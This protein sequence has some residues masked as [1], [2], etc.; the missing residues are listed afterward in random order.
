MALVEIFDEMV[1]HTPIGPS[2]NKIPIGT[3]V[4]RVMTEF[5]DDSQLQQ[6]GENAMHDESFV[7]GQLVAHV[8]P[9]VEEDEQPSLGST[10]DGEKVNASATSRDVILS[11]NNPLQTYIDKTCN[12]VRLPSFFKEREAELSRWVLCVDQGSETRKHELCRAQQSHD[13]VVTCAGV[14][15]FDPSHEVEW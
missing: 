12:T 5:L 6:N 10:I 4:S 9:M 11:D 8:E 2:I 13:G 3:M 7:E 1:E 14:L 15:A